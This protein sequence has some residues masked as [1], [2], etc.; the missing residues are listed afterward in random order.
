M[1]DQEKS[2]A[3]ADAVDSANES[4]RASESV[5]GVTTGE[6]SIEEAS[7]ESEAPVTI[8]RRR[9]WVWPVVAVVVL[10]AA[11][12]TFVFRERPLPE[13]ISPEEFAAASDKFR[14][15]YKKEPDRLDVLSL[16]AELAVA[17]GR[18]EDAVVCFAEIPSSHPRYGL[19]A[20]LQ[21]GHV[22]L[23][24]NRASEAEAS[25]RAFLSLAAQARDMP[26][27]NVYAARSRLAFILSVE[28]RIEERQSLL[29]SVHEGGTVT[30]FDSKQLFFPHLLL[31]SSTTGSNR[32]EKFLKADPDN[33]KLR[34][35]HAR[36]LT[37]RG[38]TEEAL[39]VLKKLIVDA[40]KDLAVAA[41]VLEC[42]FEA[43][44]E[45]SLADFFISAPEYRVGEPWLLTR[46]RGHLAMEQKKW[47]EAVRWFEQV[48]AA[49]RTNPSAQSALARAFRALNQTEEAE[50]ATARSATIAKIRVALAREDGLEA[51]AMN[52]EKIGMPD[53]AAV[54]RRHREMIQ[55]E[56][57]Q[58][59][60]SGLP[61]EKS[62]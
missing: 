44:D 7:V 6:P 15:L 43:G 36:Y 17:E 46:M 32:L 35:A 19:S 41:A 58:T 14:T 28:L 53:A 51:L 29:A 25:L 52:C 57:L 3:A 21:E 11:G 2:D 60:Q 30:L 24:L 33:R 40:P 45:D 12:V 61:G 22:L 16:V 54:F 18:P 37:Y 56:A 55:R 5:E 47:K 27:L 59:S 34:L 1:N 20:R 8:S 48:L 23:E 49:D 62:E 4:E 10:I 26:P 50:A 31:W 9:G 39:L 42:H 38:E 13:G